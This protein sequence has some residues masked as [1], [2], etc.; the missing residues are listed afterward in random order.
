[1][2]RH[3]NL[4][5]KAGKRIKNFDGTPIEAEAPKAAVAAPKAD[6]PKSTSKFKRGGTK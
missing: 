5:D 3:R 4:C 6:E 2:N 1:M